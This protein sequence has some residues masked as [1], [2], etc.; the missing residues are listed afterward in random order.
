MILGGLQRKNWQGYQKKLK[1]IERRRS[2]FSRLPLLAIYAGGCLLVL[3][4]IFY[5]GS[6]IYAYLKETGNGAVQEDIER[7]ERSKLT[8]SDLPS[9]LGELRPMPSPLTGD[10]VFS[11][12]DEGFVATTSYDTSLQNYIVN[13]L[14]RSRT[15]QAAVVVIRPDNGQILAMADHT[16]GDDKGTVSLCL[17]A[18]IPAASLFKIIAAAA[19]IEG[20]SFTLDRTMYFR[21][22][23]YTLYRSQLKQDKGRYVTKASFRE[24]FAGSINPVF[25]KIG[26]YDLGRVL[27]TEYA[28]R[29]LFNHEIPFDLQLAKSSIHVPDDDFGLAEIASGFNK[30]TL[31]SPLHAALITSTVANRGKMMAPWLVRDVKDES[32]RILYSAIP[33]GLSNPIRENTAE[34]LRILMMDTVAKGTCRKA[35]QPLKRKKAFRNIDLGAKTGTINDQL[36]QYKYDWLTAYALPQEGDRGICIAVLA[37]HGEMLGIRAKDLARHIINYHFIS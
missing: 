25:G 19:A 30:K 33:S 28:D 5:A 22:G 11:G 13:L 17:K 36:D 3:V 34:K 6:W 31:I 10:Y 1:M 37:I 18:D 27:M 32:G 2:I 21:G 8:R 29:F 26:I 12:E 15:H 20:R 23:K 24:A 9:L 35:F 7:I 16:K 14:G 4:S